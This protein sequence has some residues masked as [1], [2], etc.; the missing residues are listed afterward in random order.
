MFMAWIVG[1]I[2]KLYASLQTHHGVHTKDAQ[3]FVCPSQ[4]HKMV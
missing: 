2:S 1:M 3:L 4:L